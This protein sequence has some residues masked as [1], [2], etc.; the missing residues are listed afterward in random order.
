MRDWGR[1]FENG[2]VEVSR[3][4]REVEQ[5]LQDRF[6][7]WDECEGVSIRTMTVHGRLLSIEFVAK[8]IGSDLIGLTFDQRRPLLPQFCILDDE[9]GSPVE[10]LDPEDAAFRVA[11]LGIA[12]P[13]QRSELLA[14]ESG[15]LMRRM[16]AG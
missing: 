4:M 12:E 8:W 11:I 9:I 10:A 1:V 15:Q 5:L 14:D 6:S 13:F 3:W 16:Q 7:E 2:D